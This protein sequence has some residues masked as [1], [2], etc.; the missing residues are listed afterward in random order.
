ML[1]VL[2]ESKSC[3][4]IKN[5]GTVDHL[6]LVPR[7]QAERCHLIIEWNVPL[8]TCKRVQ[9][10]LL[11]DT[12]R[13]VCVFMCAYVCMY[14]YGYMY[15]WLPNLCMCWDF[16]STVLRLED[17][18][19]IGKTALSSD[20]VTILDSVFGTEQPTLLLVVNACV[21]LYMIA[22]CRLHTCIFF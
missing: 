11:L 3:F 15:F 22:G 1:S 13:C 2:W 21:T 9:V 12:G 14:V 6:G 17:Y 10:I 19:I 7:C 8:I 4:G 18:D 16:C 5:Y 20:S